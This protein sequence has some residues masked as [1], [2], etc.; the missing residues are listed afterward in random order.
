MPPF[1]LTVTWE[2]VT[3]SS[4]GTGVLQADFEFDSL[5][6]TSPVPVPAGVLLMGTALAGFGV[7]RRR[8]KRA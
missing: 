6:I 5:V 4:I 3:E 1:T 8:K 2:G 7:M